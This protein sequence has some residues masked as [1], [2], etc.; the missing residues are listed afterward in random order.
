[1]QSEFF[2]LDPRLA[3]LAD[4]AQKRAEK[5]FAAIEETTEYNQQ[6]VLSAF[7]RHQ[8]SESHLWPPRAMDTAIVEEIHW[9]RFSPKSWE[10]R[11]H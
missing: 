8:V 7:I 10:P 2:T 9:M 1:M 5:Q 6:K 3:V 4:Q 11:M